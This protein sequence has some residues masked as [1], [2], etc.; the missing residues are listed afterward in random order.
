MSE[1]DKKTEKSKGTGL[2]LIVLGALGGILLAP[3]SGRDTRHKIVKEVGDGY[4]YLVS[5]GRATGQAAREEAHHIAASGR[6]V[7]HTK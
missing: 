3:M 4:R 6:R 5:L 7:A 2:W 1:N